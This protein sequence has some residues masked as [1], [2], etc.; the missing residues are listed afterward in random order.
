MLHKVITLAVQCPPPF[1]CSQRLSEIK[2]TSNI[3]TML[4]GQ[5]ICLV[6][7]LI[8]TVAECNWHYH[9]NLII[10]SMS[11]EPHYSSEFCESP[12]R[13]FR[14]ILLNNKGTPTK[15]QPPRSLSF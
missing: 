12:P 4:Q 3:T 15:K 5:E 2:L 7:Y 8:V 6:P 9:Q 11:H 10:S 14:I 1:K 13:S